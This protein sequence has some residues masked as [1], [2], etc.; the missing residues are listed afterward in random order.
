MNSIYRRLGGLAIALLMVPVLIGLLACL[1]VPIGDP[2]RSRIDSDLNGIWIA[3]GDDVITVYLFEPY[4]KR[5]WYVEGFASYDRMLDETDETDETVE[6]TYEGLIAEIG[7]QE[8]SMF[9]EE[10]PAVFKAWLARL[11]KHKFMTW[12]PLRFVL[13]SDDPDEMFWYGFRVIKHSSSHFE[14][15]MINGD[16]GLFE[17]VE[18]KRRAYEKVI[19]KNT[20]NTELYEPGAMHLFKMS[21]EDVQR[22]ND[23]W[24]DW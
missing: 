24:N 9:E 5:T 14:L 15:H 7:D 12:E 1:P 17:D 11:G 19:R 18:K 6:M 3:P 4:D 13:M 23:D 2:E 21:D 8:P 22:L 16:S 10:G 20:E